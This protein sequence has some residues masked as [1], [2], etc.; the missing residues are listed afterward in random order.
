M[1][2]STSMT[3]STIARVLH[4]Q[5][6]DTLFVHYEST[7]TTMDAVKAHLGAARWVA[8]S[9]SHQTNARG[10]TG[11][12]WAAVATNLMVTVGVSEATLPQPLLY[13]LWVVVGVA[14]LRALRDVAPT[15]KAQLKW[16]NDVIVD[17][18]K[19]SG[20]IIESHD[21]HVLI[22]LGLNVGAAPEIVDGG[23]QATCLREHSVQ[24][25]ADTILH[26]F[27]KHMSCLVDGGSSED[28]VAALV[29][30]YASYI[31]WGQT[32]YH[33][34]EG[35]GRGDALQPLRLD[36]HGGLVYRNIVTGETKTEYA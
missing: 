27:L 28:D 36:K 6:R 33:R 25:D 7:P 14:Q 35:G 32:Y 24:A 20:T 29:D 11:R 19:L 17:S 13:K 10:T 1:Y 22:G 5:T 2:R 12:T 21:D 8:C 34:L 31:D 15:L 26:A 3:S 9:A 4:D 16:P 30:E 23:R 18:K